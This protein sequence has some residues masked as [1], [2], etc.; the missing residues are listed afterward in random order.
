M[1]KG[2]VAL[3]SIDELEQIVKESEKLY[4]KIFPEIDK[5]IEKLTKK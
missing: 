3:I 2:D 5:K 4:D 1:Q